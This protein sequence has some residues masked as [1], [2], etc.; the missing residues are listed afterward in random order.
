MVA[1]GGALAAQTGHL[2]K[3]SWSLACSRVAA[4]AGRFVASELHSLRGELPVRYRLAVAACCTGPT[5]GLRSRPKV[6]TAPLA[7]S[8]ISYQELLIMKHKFSRSVV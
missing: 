3:T 7:C 6:D 4:V 8:G 2:L 1:H 5:V